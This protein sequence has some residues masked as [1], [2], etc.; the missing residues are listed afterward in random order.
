HSRVE[1]IENPDWFV[2]DLDPDEARWEDVVSVARC[3]GEALRA[4]GLRPYLKTSGSRGLH[5]YVPLEPVYTY[6]RAAA[7]AEAVCRF[8]AERLP[9]LATAERALRARKRGQVYMDWMQNGLGK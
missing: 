7:V 8:V 1:S 5:L 4:L 2:I 3:T 9:E 6:A